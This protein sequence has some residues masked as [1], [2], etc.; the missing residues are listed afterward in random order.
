MS[1]LN[2]DLTEAEKHIYLDCLAYII[3]LNKNTD[4]VKKEYLAHQMCDVGLSVDE[5]KSVKKA[6]KNAD[7][8]KNLKT[9][10]DIRVKRFI[11]REMILLAIADHEISDKEI[12]SIYEI[13]IQAGIK[14]EK[15]D[16]F[17]IWA[18]KGIEW[19]IEGSQLVDED[20]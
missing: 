1:V 14:H 20:L 9:V 13:G 17:F 7:I 16:D 6:K 15:I 3:N 2:K 5:L 10:S 11:L 12:A 18:A 8:I 4:K 19:Q